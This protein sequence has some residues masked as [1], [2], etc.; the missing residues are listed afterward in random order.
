MESEFISAISE[1]GKFLINKNN[2]TI[3]ITA[4]EKDIVTSKPILEN[5]ISNLNS[6]N[7]PKQKITNNLGIGNDALI[8]S[9][10][11]VYAVQVGDIYKSDIQYNGSFEVLKSYLGNE[12]LHEKVRAQGGAYGCFP[13]LDSITGAFAFVSYRD[14]NVASTFQAFQDVANAVKNIAI[15]NRSLEQLI[16]RTYGNFDPLQNPYMKGIMARN[17]FLTGSSIDYFYRKLT[18]IKSTTIADL[19]AHYDPMIDFTQNA[20]RGIIGNK[21]KIQNQKDLFDNIIQL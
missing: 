8:T 20:K 14:P 5:I 19:H 9:A 1:I 16:I 12:F 17:R 13:I 18:E 6:E 7:Y 11:I 21:E 4:E 15:S 3:S 10:E 2:S